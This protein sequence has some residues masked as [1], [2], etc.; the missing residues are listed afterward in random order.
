MNQAQLDRIMFYYIRAPVPERPGMGFV[1]G[2][3]LPIP[4][5]VY[6]PCAGVGLR[7]EKERSAQQ[8]LWQK[9]G[10][11]RVHFRKD[12]VCEES[13]PTD[14][15]R[16]ALRFLLAHN[17]FYEYLAMK[18]FAAHVRAQRMSLTGDVLARD[19]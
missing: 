17:A 10:L 12:R 11:G 16:T 14:C 7:A 9:T 8:C 15:S 1:H 18:F 5:P 2:M 6:S 4:G 13:M 19:S 3:V